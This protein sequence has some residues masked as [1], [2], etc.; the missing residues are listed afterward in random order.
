MSSFE[1]NV[2]YQV[3]CSPIGFIPIYACIRGVVDVTSPS[4]KR[5][6]VGEPKCDG[7]EPIC[8]AVPLH[9]VNGR[10]G[11]FVWLARPFLFHA[12]S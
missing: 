9:T 4:I 7:K 6:V 5:L 1:E 11:H 2:L 8:T 10:T 3:N 12:A